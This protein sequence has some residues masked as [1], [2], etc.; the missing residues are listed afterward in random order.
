LNNLG[1]IHLEMQAPA[2]AA[3]L[4]R[5]ALEGVKT[6]PGGESS[7][8]YAILAVNLAIA[9]RKLRKFADAERL[10]RSALEIQRRSV[11]E[12]HPNY[13]HGLLELARV[14][15]AA[16][17]FTKADPY[18][19]RANAVVLE[20]LERSAPALAEL[21]QLSHAWMSRA[22]L[23]EYVR[24][25]A[26]HPQAW[27][28]VYSFV[29]AYKGIVTSRQRSAR[30]V[31]ETLRQDPAAAGLLAELERAS[32]EL[33]RLGTAQGDGDMPA[34]L[35]KATE[36]R[37]QLEIALAGRAA[38]FLRLRDEKRSGTRAFQRA[39]PDGVVMVDFFKISGAPGADDR[40]AAFVV[41][42]KTVTRLDLGDVTPLVKAVDDF[43]R[44]LPSRRK[45]IDGANDSGRIIHDELWRPLAAHLKNAK[46]VVVSPEDSLSHFPFA[47]CPI[48]ENRYLIEAMTVSVLPVPRMLPS[49]LAAREKSAS[50]KPSLLA[51]GDVDFDASPAPAPPPLLAS[52]PGSP[53]LHRG[54]RG[55]A[56]RNWP[57]LPGSRQ[58]IDAVAE[59]FR[60]HAPA[61]AVKTLAQTNATTAAF[62]AH[63]ATP[64]FLHV[65]THGFFAD[66]ER[67]PKARAKGGAA[68]VVDALGTGGVH[69]GLLSGLVFAGANRPS[70]SG[71]GVLTA[72]E[73]G[74]LDLSQVELA[75][76]SA[77]ETGLGSQS[78]G[79]GVLGLQRAF[80][81]AGA[82][83]TITSLWKVDDQATQTLVAR[84]YENLWAKNMS[85][86][87]ALREAQIWMMK[88]GR[89]AGVDR[90]LGLRK[91]RLGDEGRSPQ[92]W[93]AFLVAGDWR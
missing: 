48:D 45:P 67:Q 44:S 88:E 26:G 23:N 55:A 12:S 79:D 60:R 32:Q 92:Y 47:A 19:K 69:P 33:A 11:G 93:A 41:D 22:Y 73:V 49:L 81:I 91:A 39:L 61:D 25:C 34:L 18:F 78:G 71:D 35:A 56:G 51:I 64:M 74:D 75:F 70:A 38:S 8:D 16:G 59:L 30:A 36:R 82:K 53:T 62:K 1:K 90:G 6:R 68:L 46:H 80:Q 84:F 9:Q 14:F 31:R 89:S 20:N 3:P 13:A 63:A 2:L 57:R 28:D 86:A 87:E 4:L 27:P 40:L 42:A 21:T 85:K 76:L 50:A 37:E 83:T 17:D 54:A 43:R 52:A 7:P 24:A 29:L 77:C 65:A 15:D 58:E 10:C 66:P 72:L 5:E